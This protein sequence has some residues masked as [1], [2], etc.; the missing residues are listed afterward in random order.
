M[1]ITYRTIVHRA[2]RFADFT[3]FAHLAYF[4]KMLRLSDEILLLIFEYLYYVDYNCCAY[5]DKDDLLAIRVVSKRFANVGQDLVFK[6]ITFLQDE[7]GCSRLLQLSKSP[8]LCEIVQY[9]TC[10]FP[11]LEAG[12]TPKTFA[13]SWGIDRR[14]W[15]QEKFNNAYRKYCCRCEDQQ[16]L[17]D[18]HADIASLAV[19]LHRFSRLRSIKIVRDTSDLEEDWFMLNSPFTYSSAGQRMFKA[20]TSALFASGLS[21]E[22]LSLGYFDGNSPSLIGIIQDLAP[23]RLGIYQQSFRNLKKLRMLLPWV[24]YDQ[25]GGY[26]PLNCDGILALIQSAP[27]LE[28]LILKFDMWGSESAASDFLGSLQLPNLQTVELDSMFFHEPSCLVEFL[29]KHADTL[30]KVHFGPLCL[31][32]GSWENIFIK[33]RDVLALD[34]FFIK[35]LYEG[36]WDWMAPWGIEHCEGPNNRAIEEFVQ[37]QSDI[38]PFDSP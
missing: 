32:T 20:I 4:T 11:D 34:S 27:R 31:Q 38:N 2:I 5:G 33:M 37:H 30:Q 36:S 17:E 1:E 18:S 28:E 16:L 6:H 9:L 26:T 10:Y 24:V 13:A 23:E 7:E 25:D 29:S 12:R 15:T 3:H 14:D 35:E 8:Y 21:V 22:E 19:A